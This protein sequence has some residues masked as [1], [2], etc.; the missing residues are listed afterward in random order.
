MFR[1]ASIHPERLA[2]DPADR[3]VPEAAE[4]GAQYPVE[5][6]MN[7]T[8]RFQTADAKVHYATLTG[9]DNLKLALGGLEGM[10]EGEAVFVE[11]LACPGG[12]VHGPCA[13]HDSPGLLERLRVLR[14]TRWPDRPRERSTSGSIHA[15][16]PGDAV[17]APGSG[18]KRY[19]RRVAEHR[20]D[21][22]RRR[23]QLRRL[24]LRYLPQLRAGAALRATPSRQCA[25]PT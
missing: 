20:Q 10:P 8:I 12:C 24:R 11:M 5:G 6:G 7:D 4:E 9:L 17:A 13:E 23:T 3:F 19:R 14:H 2:A 25:F 21:L 1:E 22:S 16:F 18:G 15:K